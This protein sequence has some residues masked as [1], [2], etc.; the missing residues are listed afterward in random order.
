MLL[1]GY[2]EMKE[3]NVH[4]RE[5]QQLFLPSYDASNPSSIV[6]LPLDEVVDVLQVDLLL[7]IT[8]REQQV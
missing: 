4:S 8:S 3:L 5:L 2:V 6:K 7:P 1:Y